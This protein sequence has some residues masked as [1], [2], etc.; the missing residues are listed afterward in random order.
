MVSVPCCFVSLPANLM[1]L[2]V[3][4]DRDFEFYQGSRAALRS[5]T[6]ARLTLDVDGNTFTAR[7]VTIGDPSSVHDDYDSTGHAFSEPE[8]PNLLLLR[9]VV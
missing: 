7:K 3:T 8:D 6:A 5:S 1:I 4:V 2:T 9:A